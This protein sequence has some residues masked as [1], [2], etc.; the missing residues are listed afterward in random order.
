MLVLSTTDNQTFK[1]TSMIV[2]NAKELISKAKEDER[3]ADTI[4]YYPVKIG[5]GVT[6]EQTSVINVKGVDFNE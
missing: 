2:K 4:I 5:R 3:F 1:L 6:V